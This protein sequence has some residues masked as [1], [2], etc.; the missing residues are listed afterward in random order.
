MTH[1][2]LRKNQPISYEENNGKVT[3]VVK[4]KT[5]YSCFPVLL[6]NYVTENVSGV[7]KDGICIYSPGGEKYFVENKEFQTQ[8]SV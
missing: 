3:S 8:Y 4:G 2:F 7:R 1:S 6:Q 5:A